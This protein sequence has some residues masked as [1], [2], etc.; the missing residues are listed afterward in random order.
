MLNLWRDN[1]KDRAA[2]VKT[3]AL[4]NRL[5]I[6]PLLGMGYP[7]KDLKLLQRLEKY[8]KDGDTANGLHSIWILRDFRITPV[9]LY[10]SSFHA[11]YQGKIY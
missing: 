11:L 8:Y 6:E 7:I 2:A 4:L 1:E 5:F 10:G 9:K 3:D